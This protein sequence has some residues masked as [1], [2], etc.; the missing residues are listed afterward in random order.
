MP[1][2][3]GGKNYEFKA[4]IKQLLE[5]ITHSIYTNKEIFLRELIS[6]ASDAL[7]KLRFETSRGTEILDPDLPLEIS[8]T[9]DKDKKIL[10]IADTGVGMSREELIENIGTIAKS[11]S[12]EFMKNVADAKDAGGIIGKFGVGFYS[13]FMVADKVK[14][15]TKSYKKDEPAV[16]WT[17]DGSGGYEI[18]DGPAD[19][20]R[21]ATIEIHLKED[22]VEYADPAQIKSIIK[23]HSSFISFPILVDGEKANTIPALWRESKFSITPEQYKEFYEFLT[24]DSEEPLE[25]IHISVDAPVQFTALL[26]I[27]KHSQDIMGYREENR[28]L[29]LYVRRVMIQRQ[30]KELIPEYLGFVRGVVDTEDLPLNISRETLQENR[31]LRKIQTTITKQILKRLAELAKS[32][33]EKYVALWRAHEKIFKLGYNDFINRDSFAELM[34]FDSSAMDPDPDKLTSLDEYVTRAKTDQK[35][36]FYLSGPSRQALDLNPHLEMFRDKGVEVLYLYE[37]VDEFIM[38]TV[39]A[40]KEKNLK[41]AELADAEA[42]K[43]FE[44]AADKPKAE[45]LA[46]DDETALEGLLA[47]AKTILGDRVEA[48]RLS[49]RLRTSPSCLASPDGQVTSSMQKIMQ[50]ITKDTSIPKKDLEINKDHPLT[51]NLIRIYKNDADDPFISTAVEQL[52]ESALLLDGYLSDPHKMVGRINELLENSSS[53]YAD[54]KKL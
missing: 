20:K 32:D 15:V 48:V 23:K 37:P 43:D 31:V 13:V 40:F 54:M 28:G 52:F 6:N 16:A 3:K 14:I 5:I 38:D 10:T 9:A 4:E 29:D 8:V 35:D 12:A 36:I 7:D 27:P 26:F 39:R 21:G 51:R 11:G 46:K 42:L 17:S 25:T 41:S 47:K 30:S 2:G 18:E 33:P 1:E 44:S 50:M 19:A 53:W 45:E 34:R 22:A 24:Y 49:D